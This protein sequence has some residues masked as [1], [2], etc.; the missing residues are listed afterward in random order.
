MIIRNK[1]INGENINDYIPKELV[2]I[3]NNKQARQKLKKI[4]QGENNI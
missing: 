4:M 3:F 1:I 2:D